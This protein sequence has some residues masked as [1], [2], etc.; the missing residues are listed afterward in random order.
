MVLTTKTV[1]SFM[2]WKQK[3]PIFWYFSWSL[4][5]LLL[6]FK[7][8]AQKQREAQS[9][10]QR[11][12]TVRLKKLEVSKMRVFFQA[13]EVHGDFWRGLSSLIS[14]ILYF[15]ASWDTAVIN[16]IIAVSTFE[17]QTI[18]CCIA[19]WVIKSWKVQCMNDIH[20]FSRSGVSKVR[21]SWNLCLVNLLV[22]SAICFDI[23]YVLLV[24]STHP[25][26][27]CQHQHAL[28]AVSNSQLCWYQC[29]VARGCASVFPWRLSSDCPADILPL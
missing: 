21:K 5:L 16:G 9:A 28:F 2:N 13:S 4:E 26:I 14:I 12:I 25:N 19:S 24:R 22:F 6:A 8:A 3:L 10:E 23:S 29:H 1:R 17:M 11:W 18:H 27:N 20:F 15:A 7:I